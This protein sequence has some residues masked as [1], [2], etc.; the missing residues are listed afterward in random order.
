MPDRTVVKGAQGNFPFGKAAAHDIRKTSRPEFNRQLEL[1][2]YGAPW[3][4]PD[5]LADLGRW[6]VVT[7]AS[8]H[9]AIPARVL[10]RHGTGVWAP[11]PVPDL[12]GVEY[13]KYFDRTG[14]V[15]HRGIGDL[16]RYSALNQ[17]ADFANRH[18]DFRP[19]AAFNKD[20]L[21]KLPPPAPAGAA[22]GG[23]YSD[24]Q[25][26]A[27]AK[28][29]YALKPPTNPNRPKTDETRKLVARGE[30]VFDRLNCARCHGGD[31]YTSDKLTPVDGVK[32]SDERREKDRI[33]EESVGTDPTL[34]RSTRRGTGF[35]KVPSLNG[36]WYRGP[37]EHGGSVATL[38]D[39]F[40]PNRLQPDYVP[41]GWKGLPGTK[42]RAV[43]GHRFGLNVPPDERA[44]LIAFLKTL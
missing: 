14:L 8:A 13:R 12:I 39:W 23:R 22:P 38:E 34:A 1:Q 16:M 21:E 15:R 31:R 11:V 33:L 3:V 7:P 5:P 32:V 4:R 40:D 26:F 36:V 29:V 20:F 18:G 41:T 6:S 43:L 10:A 9:E 25:L 28:Y 27:L 37:F 2:L 42:T 35:Y 44:A 19:L 17:G 30:A 24:A